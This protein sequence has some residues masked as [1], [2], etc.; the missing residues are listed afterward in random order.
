MAHREHVI[1]VNGRPLRRPMSINGRQKRKT[2]TFL[3]PKFSQRHRFKLLFPGPE[4][5][6]T[7]SQTLINN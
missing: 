3:G 4:E 7:I 1:D 2:Q 5:L 6:A